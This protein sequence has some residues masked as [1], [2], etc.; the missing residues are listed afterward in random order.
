MVAGTFILT[1]QITSAF[2]DIFTAGNEKI[3]AVVQRQT[4]FDSA[5][6]EVPP[7]PE[8]IVEQVRRTDGVAVADGEVQGQGQLL[9]DGEKVDSTGGAPTLALSTIDPALNP[10]TAV[11]GRLPENPGEVALIKDT[12]DRKDITIGQPGVELATSIG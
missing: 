4:L 2:D 1:D 11:E 7:L 3:D 5:E 12:A 10:S 6:A 9:V 8:S